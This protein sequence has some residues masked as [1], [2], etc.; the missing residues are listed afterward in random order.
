LRPGEG[1][2]GDRFPGWGRSSAGRAPALQAGGHRFDPGRLHHRRLPGKRR[3]PHYT[4]AAAIVCSQTMRAA[5]RL[6]MYPLYRGMSRIRLIM[7]LRQSVLGCGSCRLNDRL[8]E[9]VVFVLL[10]CESGSGASLGACDARSVFGWNKRPVVQP[11]CLTGRVVRKNSAPT[12]GWR[13][14]RGAVNDFAGWILR[15]LRKQVPWRPSG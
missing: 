3:V 4:D 14:F 8:V 11:A 2:S 1:G 9:V 12:V 15:R 10:K 7:R 6:V 5:P 13:G